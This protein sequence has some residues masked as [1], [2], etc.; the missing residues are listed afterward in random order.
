MLLMLGDLLFPGVEAIH[1][2]RL[3]QWYLGL[4][5]PLGAIA[6]V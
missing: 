3:A 5:F 1:R 2:D 6:S 4:L